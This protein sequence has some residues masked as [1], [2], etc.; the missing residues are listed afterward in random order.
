MVRVRVKAGRADRAYA[1]DAHFA[2]PAQRAR[3]GESSIVVE[4]EARAADMA[5]MRRGDKVRVFRARV[6]G[7]LVIRGLKVSPDEWI[8]VAK[9]ARGSTR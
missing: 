1:I 8:G 6:T 9:L 5:R 2:R 4:T 3:L 7:H